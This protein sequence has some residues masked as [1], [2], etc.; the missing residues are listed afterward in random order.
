MLLQANEW[1]ELKN[2]LADDRLK[3]ICD[4]ASEIQMRLNIIENICN[5]NMFP[6]RA[7]IV[8][9]DNLIAVSY[10]HLTLPTKA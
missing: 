5:R 4:L 6:P 9:V 7:H 1:L 8:D 3:N 2:K 10:T